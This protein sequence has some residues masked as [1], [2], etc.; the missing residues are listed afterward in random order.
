M[1]F[2]GVLLTVV[3]T[4]CLLRAED[5]S[6]FGNGEGVS[7]SVQALVVQQDGKVVI[8]GT[9]TAVNGVPRQNL[10]RLNADGTL[11]AAFLPQTIDGP[12]GPVAALLLLPDGSIL[13]GGDF[14]AVGN[15]IR[16]DLVKFKPDG[17]AD[18]D[19]GKMEGGVATNGSVAALALQ[20][21]GSI[22]VGGTFTTF[23]GQPRRGIARLGADG[24]VARADPGLE[25]LNGKV[26]ALGTNSQGMAFAGGNFAVP[27]QNAHGI[28]R[29]SH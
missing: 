11:D 2:P 15:L 27:T 10:A 20:P 25:N 23:Y 21:D 6:A 13:A 7:G 9:F 18:A 26:V 8:G 22:I 29:L 16:G 5:R 17:T 24:T 1:K 4:T 14:S 28:L 12:N 19:F 3:L